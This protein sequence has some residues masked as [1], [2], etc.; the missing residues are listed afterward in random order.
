MQFI[1]ILFYILSAAIEST[2]KTHLV[3]LIKLGQQVQSMK[4]YLW[5]SNQRKKEKKE[6]K[7]RYRHMP[8][9]KQFDFD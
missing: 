2:N 9:E 3:Q 6:R 8:R 1:R 7:R 5:I 4:Q